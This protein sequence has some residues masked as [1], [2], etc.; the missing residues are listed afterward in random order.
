MIFIL[1]DF[2]SNFHWIKMNGTIFVS[3]LKALLIIS[4]FKIKKVPVAIVHFCCE[5]GSPITDFDLPCTSA[6]SALD[7][8]F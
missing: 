7:V 3:I 8:Q 2:S 1:A 6:P 4:L 5:Q